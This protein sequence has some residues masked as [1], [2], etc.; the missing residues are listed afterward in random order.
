ML[1]SLKKHLVVGNLNHNWELGIGYWELA[2]G[3]WELPIAN[4][5]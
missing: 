3:Y 2:I 1:L 5:V 4:C